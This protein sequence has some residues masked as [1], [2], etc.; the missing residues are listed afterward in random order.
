MERFSKEITLEKRNKHIGD[1]CTLFFKHD[2]LKITK[3]SKQYMYDEKDNAYLDCINNVCH[4]GH[5]HPYVVE[6]GYEQMKTLNTNSRFLHDN[7]VMLAERLTSTLPE[8]L[9][10]VYFTNSG[11]E[12][13]DLAIRLANHH[14]H[15]SEQITL[16]HAYHGH[17]ISALD[18]SPYKLGTCTDG[19]HTHSKNIHIVPCP[20]IYR[21]KYRDCDYPEDNM[22]HLYANEVKAVIDKLKK[23]KKQVSMF[24]AESMQSCA[25]QVIF[26]EGYLQ[27]VY[28]YVHD[29]GG[30]CIADEVQVGFGRAGS[31]FWTFQTQD[32]IPDIVTIGKPM[33]NGHP[34]AAVITTKD[35]SMSFKNSGMEY[36]NTYGGNPVSCAIALAVMDVIEEEKLQEN[37]LTTGKYW[38]AQLDEIK[39][40]FPIIGDVRGLGLFIGIDLVKDRE[41]REPASAEA[42]HVIARMKEEFIILSTDGPH[43]NI[44]KMKPPMCF[45][46]ENVDL[47]CQKLVM[48][49]KEIQDKNINSNANM[50]NS[51]ISGKKERLSDSDDSGV[52]VDGHHGFV[53]GQ[54]YVAVHTGES[55]S[56]TV[57]E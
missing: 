43:C 33:G 12:A 11:S 50:K 16:D 52:S 10:T 32:V 6:A 24:I 44:I 17:V 48:V 5:C 4:V 25:G 38:V 27:K 15:G 39:K 35:I 40:Q 22:G 56:V 36:F 18:I 13:T 37:A 45:T 26:P 51:V 49:L 2:P 1:A 7:L 54:E 53:N 57:V 42:K 41:T 31:H 14:T 47:V 20:D 23:E 30:I 28:K 9:N 55:D 34:V 3:A 8:G 19:I 21:G 46:K 29:A